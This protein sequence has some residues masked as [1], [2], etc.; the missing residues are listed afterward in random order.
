[1]PIFANLAYFVFRFSQNALFHDHL[2]WTYRTV[3]EVCARTCC[4]EQYDWKRAGTLF[5]PE[6]LNPGENLTLE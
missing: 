5:K 4:V 1:M 2:F 3:K 6:Y